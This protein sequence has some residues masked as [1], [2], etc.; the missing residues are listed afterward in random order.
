MCEHKERYLPFMEY[1]AARGFVCIIH[2]HRGHG[3]S[4]RSMDDLGYFYADGGANLVRD[5]HQI[6]RYIRRQFPAL[7][8][9]LFGHSMGSLAVRAYTRYYGRELD[10]LIVCGS[11]SRN[12]MMVI[13]SHLLRLS[14]AILG[15]HS[16][17]RLA[18]K[19]FMTFNRPFRA[20]HLKNAWISTDHTVVTR[21]NS[22]PL[23][24]FT[25]TINGYQSLLW[26]MYQAYL[27]RGWRVPNPDL[28]IRFISGA[29]DPCMLSYRDFRRAVACMESVGYRNV[30]WKLYP[31]M[32]HEILN[33]PDRTDVYRD[34]AEFLLA[35][36]TD[37][38]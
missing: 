22:D 21:Y 14:A 9:F 10:G 11:P 1:M 37:Q 38:S 31:G 16:H 32:R 24:N 33:E 34:I 17:F 5:L 27:T 26:L 36:V 19:L 7:P 20:E 29:E 8:L 25:F 23:C 28:P 30:S 12:P 2:D 18:D 6:T 15:D 13:G 35:A 3:G 4:V